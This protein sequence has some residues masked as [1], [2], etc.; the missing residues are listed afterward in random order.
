MRTPGEGIPAKRGVGWLVTTAQLP[1]APHDRDL[2]IH[3]MPNHPSAPFINGH[4]ATHFEN[5]EPRYTPLLMPMS[6]MNPSGIGG[7]S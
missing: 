2:A 3:L 4:V 6:V 1:G 7:I 5:F